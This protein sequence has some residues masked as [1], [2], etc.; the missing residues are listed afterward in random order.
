MAD[1][2][3]FWISHFGLA[4]RAL[5]AAPWAEDI[6]QSFA[7]KTLRFFALANQKPWSFENKNLPQEFWLGERK[8]TVSTVPQ[9]ASH[10]RYLPTE[11]SCF[12][13]VAKRHDRLPYK[14]FS[15]PEP[16]SRPVKA[17]PCLSTRT[18]SP[19]SLPEL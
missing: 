10:F 16:Y 9:G 2:E 3:R 19:K 13:G 4:T 17:A 18:P 11:F 14:S 8:G 7:F 12:A 1:T 6:A 5:L 15:N